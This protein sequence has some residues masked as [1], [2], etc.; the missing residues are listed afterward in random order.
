MPRY[1]AFLRAINVGGHTVKMDRLRGLFEEIG[2]ANVETFIAS[3]NV[4]FEARAGKTAALEKKIEQHLFAAL[5][6]GVAT[7]VRT[8]AD[9]VA[10]AAHQPFSPEDHAH[11][12][13]YLY[14][15]FLSEA[16][17]A[18]AARQ[19]VDCRDAI[20]DLA[21][22]GRQVYWL[23]RAKISDPDH[24]APPFDKFLN[25]PGTLR[26]ATTVRKLAAKYGAD[27]AKAKAK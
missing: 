15:L 25:M 27:S 10:V 3:G 7:F 20:N 9:V 6:Y 26:N 4:I 1:I 14:I 22:V 23:R 11:P 21:V 2:F 16:P 5:G 8:T 24:P 13:N 12:E 19:V 18:E 17:T